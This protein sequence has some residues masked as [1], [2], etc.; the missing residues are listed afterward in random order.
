VSAAM[1]DVAAIVSRL[2]STFNSGRTRAVEWRLRQLDSIHK[3]LMDREDEILDALHVDVGKPRLEG[4]IAEVGF[5]VKEVEHTRKNLREWMKPER[6]PTPLVLQPGKSEVQRQALGVVLVIGPWNY[7]FQLV[8]A[9][10]VAALAA[11]NTVLLKPSEVAPNTSA[12][13]TRLLPQYLEP[14]AVAVVEGG[15]PETTALLQQR[16][17]HIFYTGNGDVA[18]IIYAAAAKNLTPVTLELGGKSPCVVDRDVD[19]EVVARR[20][21]WGKFYNAGQTCVAPDYLMVHES[22]RDA[23][24][25]RIRSTVRDFYGDNPQKSPDYGRI[26]NTRHH[27]RLSKLLTSGEP[28]TRVDVDES[29]RYISP[30]VLRDV[31]A[32]SPAM[33]DEIFGPILPVLTYREPEEAVRFINERPKPLALYVF[34][35]NERLKDTIL[36]NTSSGGATVNHVWLHL[37]VPELPFGGVG[38]SGV[39]NYHGRWGFETFTHRRG[40]LQKPLRIDPPIMYPPYDGLKARLLRMLA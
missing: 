2:R 6:V 37:G 9:P 1:T 39:G 15:I 35:D 25:D 31:K 11:G 18:R 40:V 12:L 36:E 14:D 30:V 3:M 10:L 21:T 34:T 27:Q 20:I 7:P 22:V 5:M 8:M 33:T 23:L 32:D 28:V 16:F 24:L 29:D 17:D 19:L 4:W 26:V 38:E 13:L